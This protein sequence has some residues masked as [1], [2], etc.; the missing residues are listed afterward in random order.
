MP[1]SAPP[2]QAPL[3]RQI[4]VFG[5]LGGLL[6]LL[7]PLPALAGLGILLFADGRL[8]G[9]ADPSG[10]AKNAAPRAW[11]FA[12]LALVLCCF[13]AGSAVAGLSLPD[14]P[15]APAWLTD[16]WRTG[17][18]V[19]V[20]GVVHDVQ[21][22]PDA[23]L[24][25]LLRDVRPAAGPPLVGLAVLNWEQPAL[26][27]GRGQTLEAG[28]RIQSARGLANPGVDDTGERW[29]MRGV[30]WRASL[31]GEKGDVRLD[32]APESGWL[33]RE[34]LRERLAANLARDHPGVDQHA[35]SQSAG[36]L[37][38]LVFGDRF[39]LSSTLLQRLSAASLVHSLAL[40]GQHLSVAGLFAVLLVGAAGRAA[41]GIFL[42]MPRRKAL[43][44]A[45]LPP[46][47]LYLWLGDAPPSLLRAAIML[48]LF[49][50]WLLRDRVCTLGDAL[51]G[52]VFCI[53]LVSPLTIY[54]AGLQLSALSVAAIALCAPLLRRLPLPPA[55]G[56]TATLMRRSAQ[57]VCVSFCIQLALTPVLLL[58]FHSAGPW[59]F[60]NLFWLPVMDCFVLPLSL[61]GTLLLAADAQAAA[62]LL[63]TLAIQ[64]CEL[65]LA[66]LDFM[67]RHGLLSMPSLLRPHWTALLAF[68][69]LMAVLALLP[70]RSA[71]PPTGRRL[72]AAS[73]LLFLI[74]PGLR[75]LDAAENTPSLRLID[76]GQGQAVL[77][78]APGG[79]RMLID[80]GGLFS[81]RFDIGRD[82]LAPALCANHA[83]RL[84]WILNSHPDRDHL[85]G[86]FHLLTHFDVGGFAGNGD[87]GHKLAKE[88][89]AILAKQAYPQSVLVAGDSIRL[90][91]GLRVDVLHPP[92]GF[93]GSSN[94]Q[95]LV[96]RL[97]WNDAP[98]ALIPGDVERPA[99]RHMLDSGLD[100]R[101]PVLVLPHHGGI[102]SFAPELYDAVGARLALVSNGPSPRYPAPGARAAL[103]ERGIRLMETNVSGQIALRWKD[104]AQPPEIRAA[105][106]V[107]E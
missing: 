30:F 50:F 45:S 81:P 9:P 65:L 4:C 54:D 77:L 101:A 3:F 51:C 41:P 53:T 64:P 94:N 10:I 61:A 25:I 48:G 103:A 75:V 24:R 95:S 58:L 21:G 91:H 62:S 76:V 29:R 32:G 6:S 44:L 82:V 19:R 36:V 5:W 87:T 90:A 49:S 97:L 98:L 105:R 22:L 26:R 83:P 33:L 15:T 99:I 47:L 70:G 8:F 43:L 80:G 40:S 7:Y 74:G 100:L 16:A 37:P 17:E 107:R 12:R 88:L 27:P 13:A 39:F 60:L 84:M 20:T 71:L 56:F 11:R 52:A 46:A 66:A 86:L 59:F 67:A 23:R 85:H 31:R 1:C 93:R 92:A 2:L 57:I 68:L 55:K 63:C 18:A 38:A 35:L 104:P 73:A 89:A 79:A 96:L 42:R 14:V 102:S 34:R 106:N 28:L 72:L 69:L 78:Q